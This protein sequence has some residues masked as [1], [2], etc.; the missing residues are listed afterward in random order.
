MTY[1]VNVNSGICHQLVKV[2]SKHELASLK[3]S[4]TFE[5]GSGRTTNMVRPETYSIL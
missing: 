1:D 4:Q 2:S 5:L 3:Y